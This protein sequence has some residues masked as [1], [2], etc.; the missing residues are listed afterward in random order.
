VTFNFRHYR[1][2]VEDHVAAVQVVALERQET[3]PF[4]QLPTLGEFMRGIRVGRFQDKALTMAQIE[5]R[6]SIAGRFS[7]TFFSAFGDV[8]SSIKTVR[9]IGGKVSG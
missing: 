1:T 5:Y 2:L 6:F 3:V 8:A 4:N 9:L 7:G